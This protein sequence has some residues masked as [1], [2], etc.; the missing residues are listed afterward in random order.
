MRL[1]A[2]I[3]CARRGSSQEAIFGGFLP[4]IIWG[5][6]KLVEKLLE[7]F[8]VGARFKKRQHHQVEGGAP[9]AF[10]RITRLSPYPRTSCYAMSTPYSVITRRSIRDHE[11][12]PQE[13]M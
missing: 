1:D 6:G 9:R 2:R 11:S 10:L 3:I 7:I 12:A 8:W 5:E 4:E 13:S